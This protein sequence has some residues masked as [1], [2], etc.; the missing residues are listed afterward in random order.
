[1]LLSENSVGIDY[2]DGG[3]QICVLSPS[4]DSLGNSQ[5]ENDIDEAIS[6]ISRFGKVG[7]VAIEACTGSANFATKLR[8]KTGWNTKLC[9][10]GYARRMK[11]NPD[12]TDWADARLL[13]DLVR[14]G[15]LPEVFLAPEEQREWRTL[16]RYRDSVV[17]QR[18]RV[19]LRIR[20]LLRLHRVKVPAGNGCAWSKKWT[21]YLKDNLALP[22]E[23]T[24][25]FT[26]LFDEH[27]WL[28]KKIRSSERRIAAKAKPDRTIQKLMTFKGVGL[29]TAVV[30]R[31][32]VG[33]FSRFATG[34]QLAR[35]CGVTPRN[36]SSGERV[37]DSGLVKAGNP[38]LKTVLMEMSHNIRR[39]DTRWAMFATKLIA[40][41]KPASVVVAAVANRW[42][43]YLFHQMRE[44][45]SCEA[46]TN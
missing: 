35:Y 28:T 17:R 6:Y 21:D 43:R 8:E 19:K 29:I 27:E 4:G 14:V 3:I 36:A 2:H 10:P 18:R 40:R 30:L 42:V 13:S 37:A 12:K 34:K 23:S 25:V 1:M 5:C 16:I 44:F 26:E 7:A 22:E 33:V 9:H 31:A 38:L 41:G 15:Y 20:A 11:A 32:E 39:Y 24:W 46:M 45:E